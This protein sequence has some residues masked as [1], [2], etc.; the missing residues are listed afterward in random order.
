MR[1]VPTDLRD[2]RAIRKGLR[3]SETL[4]FLFCKQLIFRIMLVLAAFVDE[5]F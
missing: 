2:V 4:L 3:T 5:R 1:T